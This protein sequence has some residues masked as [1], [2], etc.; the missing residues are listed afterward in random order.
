MVRDRALLG[1]AAVALYVACPLGLPPVAHAA[2][3]SQTESHRAHHT[4]IASEPTPA[5]HKKA[6]IRQ[7]A[8]KAAEPVPTAAAVQIPVPEVDTADGAPT[9]LSFHVASASVPPPIV[10]AG[11]EPDADA[12][13]KPGRKRREM[14]AVEAAIEIPAMPGTPPVLTPQETEAGLLANGRGDKTFVMVDKAAGKIIL[15]ENGQPVFA[16]PALTGESTADQMPKTELSERFD[17]LNAPNTKITPAGRYTVERGFDPEV[18][19]PLF[20]IH[21]IRGKDWGIAI[22]QLYL[23]IPSEHRDAR[24]LSPSEEDKHITYGCINVQSATL[25]LLMHELPVKGPIPLYILPED[26]S[27]TAAYLSPHTSS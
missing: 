15:F 12:L 22:H 8:H 23:G 1:A 5:A 9:P 10:A 3:V 24:I 14:A 27:Q 19:G 20:D 21:E 7:A 17:T 18:G 26:A 16:G 4:A 2:P 13:P 6:A 11:P 25:H